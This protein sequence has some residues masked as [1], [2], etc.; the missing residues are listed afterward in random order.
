MNVER[1]RAKAGERQSAAETASTVGAGEQLGCDPE[2][3]K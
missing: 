3:R 1:G 2:P